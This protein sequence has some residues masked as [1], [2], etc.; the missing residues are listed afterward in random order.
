VVQADIFTGSLAVFK[1]RG[2]PR[3][4]GRVAK[5]GWLF[6]AAFG[7]EIRSNYFQDRAHFSKSQSFWGRF[8]SLGGQIEGKFPAKT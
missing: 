5:S 6:F 2:E 1:E 7:G 3:R 4:A 8:A